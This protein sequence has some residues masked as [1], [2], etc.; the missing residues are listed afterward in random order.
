MAAYENLPWNLTLL[1]GR[2]RRARATSQTVNVALANPVEPSN[3][4]G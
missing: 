1:L 2:V 4:H 3:F